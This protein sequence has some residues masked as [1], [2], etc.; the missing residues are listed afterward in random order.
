MGMTMQKNTRF[1]FLWLFDCP[2]DCLLLQIAPIEVS[3]AS[4]V[5]LIDPVNVIFKHVE[6]L[7]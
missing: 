4:S 2:S 5:N 3:D 7:N 1:K 6:G